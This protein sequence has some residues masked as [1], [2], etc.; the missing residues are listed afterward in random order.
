[1]DLSKL[2]NPYDFANPITDPHLFAG[3]EKEM[4]EIRYYLDY[5]SKS[6]RPINL[7]ILGPRASGKTSVLNM[8][9]HEA[10]KRGLLL[11]G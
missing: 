5:A 1:M 9:E 8:I 7:A 3:R 6:S 4:E 2:P 10:K 11:L